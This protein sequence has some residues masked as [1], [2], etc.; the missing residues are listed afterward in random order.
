MKLISALTAIL[1]IA[2]FPPAHAQAQAQLASTRIVYNCGV[3]GC[4]VNC[5]NPSGGWYQL[6]RASNRVFVDTYANG[7]VQ[8]VFE[9]GVNGVRAS[10]LSPANLPCKISGLAS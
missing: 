8:Y 7:N 10:M 2:A 6:D 4:V 1:S 9:D 5:A 3:S